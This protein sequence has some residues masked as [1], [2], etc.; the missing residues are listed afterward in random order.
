MI[1]G[2]A[3]PNGGPREF[4]IKARLQGDAL[5]GEMQRCTR[6][7]HLVADSGLSSVYSVP[8]EATV[9]HCGMNRSAGREGRSSSGAGHGVDPGQ[10]SLDPPQAGGAGNVQ[11]RFEH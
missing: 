1:G 9:H 8:M 6:D 5:R 7:P 10:V 2:G 11:V 3:C 4:L